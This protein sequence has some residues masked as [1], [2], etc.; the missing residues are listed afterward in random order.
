VTFL[1]NHDQPRFLSSGNAKGNLERLRVALVFLYTARGIPCL[2]YGTEQAF[3]GGNDPYD[4]E[5]MFAGQFEQGPS[6]GD[7]F[8]MA[9]PLFQWVARLNNLRRLYPA[10]QT[11]L[12]SN[13]W[14]NPKGPGLFAYARRLNP[15]T[16]PGAGMAASQPTQEL[17][18]ILNTAGSSQTLPGRPTI[19]PAGTTLVNLLDP[20]ETATVTIGP[21]TP[22]IT[23]PGTSSKVF[24]AQ[25]QLLPLDPVVTRITPP[26]DSTNIAT[27]APMVIRFSQPMDTGSVESAFS[28]VPVVSGAFA[29]S[30]SRETMTFTPGGEGFPARTLVTV[31]IA[32]A[33]RD[34]AAHR[35]FYAAFES[36]FKTRASISPTQGS[37]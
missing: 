7:N 23:V 15:A 17:I 30:P 9:H 24:V 11:G 13:L 28:T 2:Y 1:D 29:W 33:A 19:Y 20:Q 5:D 34:A 14:C 35:M 16:S 8:N 31:R 37:P 21:R 10:L 27:V 18:V 4:R 22:A 26:H 36:R 32:A 25:G 6:V 12:H 3:N